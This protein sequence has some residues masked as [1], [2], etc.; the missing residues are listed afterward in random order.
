MI[1]MVFLWTGWS[2][3]VALG[4]RT[5]DDWHYL[6]PR[7]FQTS[8]VVGA[9]DSTGSPTYFEALNLNRHVYIFEC[10]GGDCTKA[11]I[12]NGPTLYVDGQ[13]LSPIT[14]TFKDANVER[15][16]DTRLHVQVQTS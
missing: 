12:I 5:L 2:N 6:R 9:N 11:R 4:Q 13:D 10:P 15:N 1:P 3:L 14:I 16:L 7:V 8:A